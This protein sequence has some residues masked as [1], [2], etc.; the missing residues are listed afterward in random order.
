MI[1]RT[2][3]ELGD[4]SCTEQL[5]QKLVH[6]RDGKLVLGRPSVEGAAVNA[7]TPRP[8]RL[9]NEEDWRGER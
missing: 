2:Q 1:A 4:E 8:V 5:V 7:K 6:H 3:V 9:V